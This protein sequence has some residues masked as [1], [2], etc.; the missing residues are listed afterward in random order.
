[1]VDISALEKERAAHSEDVA[2]FRHH[3]ADKAALEEE[4]E[5]RDLQIQALLE[6]KQ[7]KE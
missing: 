1:M 5:G 2:A 6:Y 7:R 4:L 3:V